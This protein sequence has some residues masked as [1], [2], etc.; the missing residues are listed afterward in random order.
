MTQRVGT[1]RWMAPEVLRNKADPSGIA[2]SLG[3]DVYSFG[4]IV[5]EMITLKLPWGHIP[6]DFQIEDHV[7]AGETLGI[8]DSTPSEYTTIMQACWKFTASERPEFTVLINQIEAIP[9]IE[10]RPEEAQ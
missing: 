8:P 5:W 3:S 4:I 10:G 1:T 7:I 2:Y 6:F 9:M